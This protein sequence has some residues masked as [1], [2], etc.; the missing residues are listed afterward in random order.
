MTCSINGCERPRL[1][2]GFCQP[3][4]RRYKKY[5]DANLSWEPKRAAWLRRDGYLMRTLSDGSEVLA[6]VEI[7][8]KALGH[9]LKNGEEVHHVNGIKADNANSNLV[10]CPNR[11]YHM[12][13]HVRQRALDACGNADWRK[14]GYCKKYD[15]TENLTFFNVKGQ[16]ARHQSCSSRYTAERKARIRKVAK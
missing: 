16:M 2:L 13:L 5:G 7:A 10:I 3:H 4:Y 9:R 15:A 6:H 14:C 11:D 12:L 1:A 8:E